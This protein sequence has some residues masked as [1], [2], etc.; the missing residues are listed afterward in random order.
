MATEASQ[1]SSTV[2]LCGGLPEIES[3]F[4]SA[5]PSVITAGAECALL[6]RHKVRITIRNAPL[7]GV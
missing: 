4:Y 1:Q 7:K 5:F 2:L 6:Y 3:A